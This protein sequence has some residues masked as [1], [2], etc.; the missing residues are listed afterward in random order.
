[1]TVVMNFRERPQAVMSDTLTGQWTLCI[2]K[3]SKY[4]EFLEYP[5]QEGTE[6]GRRSHER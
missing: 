1:M 5:A 4:D 2:I 6:A 3:L